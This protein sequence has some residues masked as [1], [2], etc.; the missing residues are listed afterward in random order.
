[1]PLGFRYRLIDTTGGEIGIVT[2]NAPGSRSATRSTCRTAHRP[3]SLRSTTTRSTG[4][5]GVHA[6]LVVDA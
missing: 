2:Y 4:K 5:G 1:M 6:T 3:R